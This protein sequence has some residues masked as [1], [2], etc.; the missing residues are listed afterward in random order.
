MF[1]LALSASV[2]SAADG[3]SATALVRDLTDW[4]QAPDLTTRAQWAVFL[5]GA[6]IGGASTRDVPLTPTSYNPVTFQS[7][8]QPAGTVAI[9]LTSEGV[10]R[11]QAVAV[12][13]INTD[14]EALLA[15]AGR[16]YY[17]LSQGRFLFKVTNGVFITVETWA[18]VLTASVTDIVVGSAS[19]RLLDKSTEVYGFNTSITTASLAR[20][21]LAYLQT[22]GR[23]RQTLRETYTDADLILNGA[24]RQFGLGYY[25]DAAITIVAAQRLLQMQDSAGCMMQSDPVG[26]FDN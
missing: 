17:R 23:A 13:V 25:S 3:S 16:I 21:N 1:Q 19:P 6:R 26:R 2:I 12:P 15:P 4:T 7:A 9:P 14:A 24:R 11:F 18:D 22:S 8:G 10:F 5:V 20:L